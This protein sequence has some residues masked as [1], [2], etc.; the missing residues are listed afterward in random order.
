MIQTFE[1]ELAKKYGIEEA[2][3]IDFFY[4]GIKESNNNGCKIAISKLI[5]LIPY[6]TY[7]QAQMALYHLRDLG[8]I[9]AKPD[10][11][12]LNYELSATLLSELNKY[13]KEG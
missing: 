8:L 2:I 11:L 10:T 1:N 5:Q 13:Y 3:L 7:A 4:K 9:V 6:M 12:V